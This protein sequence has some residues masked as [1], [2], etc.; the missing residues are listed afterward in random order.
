MITKNAKKTEKT[1]SVRREVFAITLK[2]QLTIRNQRVERSKRCVA[3]SMAEQNSRS[4]WS[5]SSGTN[6]SVRQ[7]LQNVRMAGDAK[8]RSL[9]SLLTFYIRF[10]FRDLKKFHAITTFFRWSNKK[11]DFRKKAHTFRLPCVEHSP[12]L[13]HGLELHRSTSWQ[14]LPVKP[15]RQSQVYGCWKKSILTDDKSFT[16]ALKL[17]TQSVLSSVIWRHKGQRRNLEAAVLVH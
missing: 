15:T 10:A 2:V 13:R 4:R 6:E 5:S 16:A 12:R 11:T 14:R 3:Y 8:T 17:Q 1:Y 9:C 7:P